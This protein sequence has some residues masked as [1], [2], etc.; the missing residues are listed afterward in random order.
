MYICVYVCVCVWGVLND[1]RGEGTGSQN[2][3]IGALSR[4]LKVRGVKDRAC[5]RL[6]GETGVGS[7]VQG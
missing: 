4:G 1:G 6:L 7:E 2:K 5:E 3:R